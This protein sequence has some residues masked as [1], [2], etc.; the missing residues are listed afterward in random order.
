MVRILIFIVNLIFYVIELLLLAR[1]LLKLFA[2]NTA[3]PFVQWVY[4]NS[5]VLVAPFQ[6]I[7]PNFRLGGFLIDI[8]TLIALIVYILI[9]RLII[10]ILSFL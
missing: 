5:A 4:S 6:N 2:A 3:A 7:F 9:G 1:F 8:P 10:Y